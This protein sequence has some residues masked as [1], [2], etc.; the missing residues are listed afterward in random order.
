MPAVGASATI[1]CRRRF[2]AHPRCSG[3][4][5][6]LKHRD[7]TT[8]LW[9][10]LQGFLI[11]GDG[12]RSVA[13]VHVSLPKTVVDVPGLRISFDVKLENADRVLEIIGANEPIA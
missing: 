9:I 1:C 2:P 8:V 7:G 11:V 10:Q 6:F 13:V 3:C 4:V 12:Q 5:E